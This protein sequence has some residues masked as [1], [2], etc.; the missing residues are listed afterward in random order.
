MTASTIRKRS[1]LGNKENDGILQKEKFRKAIQNIAPFLGLV[2]LIILFQTVSQGKL[3]TLRNMKTIF[4]QMFSVMLCASGVAFVISQGGLDFSIGAVVGISAAMGA[5]LSHIH[6]LLGLMGTIVT[7]VLMG[8]LNSVLCVKLKINS[9]VA[10]LSSQYALRGI[11]AV[12][13]LTPIQVPVSMSWIDN[14]GLKLLVLVFICGVVYVLFE[15]TKL[16][17][18]SKAIGSGAL[19]A[20]QSGV[21][22]KKLR[23]FAYTIS[24]L[25]AGLCGFFSMVRSGSVSPLTA[26]SQEMEVLLALVLGGMPLSGGASSKV[27]SIIIGSLMIAVLGN[28]LII[29]GINDSLQQGIRGA[30]FLI[31]VAISF[32]RQGIAYIK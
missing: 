31:A 24:G 6:P 11:L 28:G 25:A 7:G 12:L 10:T 26:S 8:Y 30:I 4:N 29:W 3:L 13:T 17:I 5:L 1:N 2:L 23:T 18:H 21:N 20:E 14:A 19:A 15:H 16:G 32:E 22:V 9:A 27:R